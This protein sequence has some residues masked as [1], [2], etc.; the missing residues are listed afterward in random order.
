[1][2]ARQCA[3][4]SLHGGLR[5]EDIMYTMSLVRIPQSRPWLTLCINYYPEAQMI[6]NPL[7]C[8]SPLVA[9]LE[10]GLAHN[11]MHVIVMITTLS[12]MQS[13]SWPLLGYTLPSFG[14][15][16]GRSKRRLIMQSS[17]FTTRHSK[18]RR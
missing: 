14:I 15:V 12:L 6:P 9:K 16:I 2:L 13:S 18:R 3:L 17:S 10:A 5:C 7:H 11:L 8:G 4:P 1:M